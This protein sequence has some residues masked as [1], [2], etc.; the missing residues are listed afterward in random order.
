MLGLVV[1]GKSNSESPQL[2]LTENTVKTY[3]TRTTQK[4]DVCVTRCRP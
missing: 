4:L 1:D 2:F 3:V